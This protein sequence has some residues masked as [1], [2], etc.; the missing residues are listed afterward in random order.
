MQ[1]DKFE[2]VKKA[3]EEE[4]ENDD[5][6]EKYICFHK[7]LKLKTE[8]EEDNSVFFVSRNGLEEKMRKTN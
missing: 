4:E 2:E 1:N 7:L 5:D 6:D 3:E 8:T